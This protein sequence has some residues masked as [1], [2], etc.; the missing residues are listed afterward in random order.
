MP[1]TQWS[2]V[3]NHQYRKIPHCMCKYLVETH[4]YSN[5]MP[6][7]VQLCYGIVHNGPPKTVLA[8]CIF[9]SA[10]GRWDF[11]VWELTRLVR[12]PQLKTPISKLVSKAIG[13][14]RAKRKIDLVISFADSSEDHHGGIYQACSW[15]YS[16]MRSDRLD[17]FLVDGE[18]VPARTCNARWGTSSEI[19]L[20]KVLSDKIVEP[21]YDGGKHLYWKPISKVGI[22][23]ALSMGLRS[24]SYPKP[25]LVNGENTTVPYLRKGKRKL[26]AKRKPT[27]Y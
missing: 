22:Q 3:E 4:H 1:L 19:E 2:D 10:T 6:S 5:R 24:L 25:I 23:K 12:I 18:F 20:P 15:I 9:S 13:E 26:K 16:G 17:G 27:N 11:P 14:I 8:C 7:S 21:R